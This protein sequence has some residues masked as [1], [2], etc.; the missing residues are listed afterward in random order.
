MCHIEKTSKRQLPSYTPNF[1]K[2]TIDQKY[3]NYYDFYVILV[4]RWTYNVYIILFFVWAFFAIVFIDYIYS[5]FSEQANTISESIQCL[6]EVKVNYYYNIV[7]TIDKNELIHVS[8]RLRWT[9]TTVV[10]GSRTCDFQ[11]HIKKVLLKK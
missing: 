7:W 1:I 8:S 6:K 4:L 10:L 9:F 11:I 5:A 3:I 2:F